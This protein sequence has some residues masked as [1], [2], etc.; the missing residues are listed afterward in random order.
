MLFLGSGADVD[1][2]AFR[3]DNTGSSDVTVTSALVDGFADG[4]SYQIWDSLI[5]S[6]LVIHPGQK[7][8]FAQTNGFNFDTSEDSPLGTDLLPSNAQPQI[9]PGFQPGQR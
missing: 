3:L 1:S 2:G 9:H 5:G 7:A 6:G 4:A 8:I